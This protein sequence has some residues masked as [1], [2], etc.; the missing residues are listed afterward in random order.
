MSNGLT[1]AAAVKHAQTLMKFNG[2][3]FVDPRSVSNNPMMMTKIDNTQASASKKHIKV[4]RS[5]D[6]P[7]IN[8]GDDTNDHS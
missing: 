8:T 1:N 2:G 4:I 3:A 6:A 7:A 5:Q